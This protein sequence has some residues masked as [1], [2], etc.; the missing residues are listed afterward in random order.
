MV[1]QNQSKAVSADPGQ[2]R[3]TPPRCGVAENAARMWALSLTASVWT[4]RRD[5]EDRWEAEETSGTFSSH[6]Y[7]AASPSGP[8]SAQL[9][10]TLLRI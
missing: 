1:T 3:L 7:G 8:A 2:A 9:V 10:E 5:A 6:F 4:V